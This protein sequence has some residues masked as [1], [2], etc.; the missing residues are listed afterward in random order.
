MKLKNDKCILGTLIKH[1]HGLYKGLYYLDHTLVTHNQWTSSCK[2]KYNK[3]NGE[4]NGTEANKK[5]L[6][7]S[8]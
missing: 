3:S 4:Q 7:I 6:T 8:L 5:H 1:T 2:S